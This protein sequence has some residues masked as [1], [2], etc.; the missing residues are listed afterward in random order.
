MARRGAYAKGLAKREEIVEAALRVV[1]DLGY[2]K[3]SV[4]EI[5]EAVGLSPA[6]LLH[7]FGSKEELWIAILTAR[8]VSDTA[9]GD[10]AL[11]RVGPAQPGTL[12]RFRE[13]L[14]HNASVPGLVR[15]YVQFAADAAEPGHPGREYLSERGAALDRALIAEIIAGQQAGTVRADLDPAWAARALRALADGLQAGWLLDPEIDMAADI[16]RF[17][18][19][20][21]PAEET[22]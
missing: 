3:A 1:A 22:A 10:A 20:L 13:I 9:L 16:D 12:A 8:D 6:G 14:A 4:R 7:H 19:L 5:A 18:A 17:V 11:H 2:R 15:L 21:A